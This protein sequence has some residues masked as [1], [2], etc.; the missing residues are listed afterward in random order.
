MTSAY[1][2]EDLAYIHHVGFG[3]L[4]RQAAP[5]VVSMLQ[6][7][8][9]RNG[10]VVELGGGGG[11]LLA[12]L[13]AAGYQPIGVDSSEP[14]LRVARSTAPSATLIHG[15]L[16]DVT[17]PPCGAVIAMGE[18]LNYVDTADAVPPM[19]SLFGR[20]AGAL[21]ANGLLLFDVMVRRARTAVPDR[22]WRAGPDWAVLIDVASAGTPECIVR[23][24][25]TFRLT[26]GTYRRHQERHL[27]HLFDPTALRE[28]LGGAGF[29]V[30]RTGRG[31]GP[32]ALEP[33]RLLFHARRASGVSRRQP[34]PAVS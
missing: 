21:P 33:N 3:D 12:A 7:A 15:S 5:A 16:H 31:Y 14:M 4:A 24:I 27:V 2:E 32:A 17:I 34:S 1:Y 19:R 11:I 18:G 23:N 20:I 25:T 29:R 13:A 10:P 28:Q 8:G 26:H 9:I 22:S 30:V 6:H